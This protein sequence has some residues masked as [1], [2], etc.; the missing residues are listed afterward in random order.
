MLTQPN[1][2]TLLP[3]W[4]SEDLERQLLAAIELE[5][6][7]EDLRRRTQH[8]GWRYDYKSR[9]V[10]GSM[11]LGDLPLWTASLVRRMMAEGRL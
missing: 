10:D 4:I 5:N 8:Y 3:D 1:G 2:L 9:H 6:W 7:R 11:R